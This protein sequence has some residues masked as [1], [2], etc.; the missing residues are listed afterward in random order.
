MS[1]VLYVLCG[2]SF[3][4][5]STLAAAIAQQTGA[6]IVSLDEI[7]AERG[8]YGGLGIPDEEWLLSH[9]LAL[10][11]V[12]EALAT[13]RSVVVDDTNCF[14]FLRDAY[15]AVAVRLDVKALLLY[16]DL[17]MDTLLARASA[18]NPTRPP[19][20]RDVLLELI[21]KFEA[22]APEE[23]AIMVPPGFVPATWVARNMGPHQ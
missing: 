23:Q 15:R 21:G 5:K 9:Q 8:L 2:M 18:D 6:V 20:A 22:P 16:L 12:E 7:N 3:S 1:A 17:P 4:G 19:V 13:G 10:Q 11:R 14:R